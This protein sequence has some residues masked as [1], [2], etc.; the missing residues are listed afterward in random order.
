MTMVVAFAATCQAFPAHRRQSDGEACPNRDV[1]SLAG[2]AGGERCALGEDRHFGT[3]R[4]T[5]REPCEPPA[6]RVLIEAVLMPL[7]RVVS[8]R[9]ANWPGDSTR[10]VLLAI[11]KGLNDAVDGIE[12]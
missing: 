5:K 6:N 10:N 1:G 8:F 2:E 12:K 11:S 4:N 7:A 9:M 3:L